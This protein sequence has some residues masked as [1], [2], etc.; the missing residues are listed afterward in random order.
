[1]NL[2]DPQRRTEMVKC[3]MMICPCSREGFSWRS[4]TWWQPC[5]TLLDV[6]LPS[7]VIRQNVKNVQSELFELGCKSINSTAQVLFCFCSW[8]FQFNI[9]ITPLKWKRLLKWLWFWSNFTAPFGDKISHNT[10]A[11][12]A[13]SRFFWGLPRDHMAPSPRQNRFFASQL[14]LVSVVQC[15]HSQ[16]C[17]RHFSVASVVVL[18]SLP[19]TSQ[20]IVRP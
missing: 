14:P 16:M 20:I 15:Y 12:C 17:C 4:R 8:W 13:V 2:G 10:Y 5:E 19:A 18:T 9:L 7:F 6:W 3:R 1:M 11:L